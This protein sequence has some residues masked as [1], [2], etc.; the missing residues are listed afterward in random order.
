MEGA[1]PA[2]PFRQLGRTAELAGQPSD[3][4]CRGAL[5]GFYPFPDTTAGAGGRGLQLGC[6]GDTT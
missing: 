4:A 1:H 2:P 5:L 6:G 3:V